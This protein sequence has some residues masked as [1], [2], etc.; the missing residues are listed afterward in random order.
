MFKLQLL[1][2]SL[3]AGLNKEFGASQLQAQLLPWVPRP[4]TPEQRKQ[5]LTAAELE[6]VVG[7]E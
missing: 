4:R 3:A 6:P 1:E 7:V 5:G 2:A